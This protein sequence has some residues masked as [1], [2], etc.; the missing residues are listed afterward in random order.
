MAD[1]TRKKCAPSRSP[2]A[3]PAK[4]K[5]K[6]DA[7][8]AYKRQPFEKQIT[9]NQAIMGKLLEDNMMVRVLRGA[10]SNDMVYDPKYDSQSHT[11]NLG[12]VRTFGSMIWRTELSKSGTRAA[13]AGSLPSHWFPTA[14]PNGAATRPASA[15]SGLPRVVSA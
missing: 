9:R 10:T 4:T 15:S 5:A 12:S 7:T 6:K 13:A 11:R 1:E 3:K 2:A 8:P 14:P